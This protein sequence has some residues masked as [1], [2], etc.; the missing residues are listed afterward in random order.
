M[1]VSFLAQPLSTN[2]EQQLLVK[3]YYK[4]SRAACKTVFA[5]GQNFVTVLM[6]SPKALIGIFFMH[7]EGGLLCSRLRE[8][9]SFYFELLWSLALKRSFLSLLT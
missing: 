6:K 5:N 9:L 7:E 8:S 2:R 3:A 4:K 1:M